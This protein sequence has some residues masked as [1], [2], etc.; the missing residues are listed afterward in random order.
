MAASNE[1]LKVSRCICETGR[2][3]HH[4]PRSVHIP[5]EV[6]PAVYA[7]GHDGTDDDNHNMDAAGVHGAED[8]NEE[9][10]TED[11]EEEEGADDEGG[12][13][14]DDDGNNGATTELW[15]GWT[16]GPEGVELTN[17]NAA[18]GIMDVSD[19]DEWTDDGPGP[20]IG[21]AGS[22]ESDND[23]DD[24]MVPQVARWR[25]NL[26]ALSQV[27][28]LYFVAYK[29]Q[30]HVSRPRSCVTNTL[31]ATPDLVLKPRPSHMS[32]LVGGD[33]DRDN[34]HQVNHLIVGD[35][36]D[37]EIL[38][39]AYDDGDVI[40]Y[41]TR[42][43]DNALVQGEE[44]G[45]DN[46][47]LVQPFFHENVAKSAWGLAVHKK[48]RLIAVGSN[49]HNVTVFIFALTGDPYH[50]IPGADPAELFRNLV[51]DASGNLL[52][53][54]GTSWANLD[55]EQRAQKAAAMENVVRRRDANWRI[56]LETN[57]YGNNIPNVAFTNDA[58]GEAEK[59][60]AVDVSGNLW[61]MD[62][63]RFDK[64][65]HVRIEQIHR[66][67]SNAASLRRLFEDIGNPPRPRGWGVLVLPESSFLPVE[68]FQELLGLPASEIRYA[69]SE[70]IGH[71]IDIS[72]GIRHVKNNSAQHPWLRPN[73]A[74]RSMSD[75]DGDPWPPSTWF[76]FQDRSSSRTTPATRDSRSSPSSCQPSSRRR[77]LGVSSGN[78]CGKA[79]PKTILGDGSSI[80]RTY[81][82]D[83]E[84]RSFEEGGVGIMFEGAIRQSRRRQLVIPNLALMQERLSNLLH[85]PELS[86]VVAASMCGRVA[87]LTLT[88]PKNENFTFRRGF[89]IEA[90]LPTRSDEDRH[91]RPVCPLL[92]VAVSPVFLAD[93][94]A[95]TDKAPAPRR[96]RIMLH[97][98]DLRILSYELSRDS[99]TDFL[100]VV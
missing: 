30:I 60:A 6:S 65:P 14:G 51:K 85:V 7:F 22:N 26:T 87:L 11:E 47:R 52:N 17:P 5:F 94:R 40:A 32:F 9:G 21:V 27:Y 74:P 45:V 81:E 92:G 23:E 4:L 70:R 3:R 77:Q 58:D 93:K 33:I 82:T 31:P 71:W 84:L 89:K 49:M 90:I 28:N 18:W 13:D 67:P 25:L 16:E 19:E 8:E 59:I 24:Q 91:L 1:D 43:I 57:S 29:N 42:H 38:L 62:I 20:G 95:E 54:S 39:L 10:E 79:K 64:C 78:L 83:L 75:Q 50:H 96:Y 2:K 69:A 76:D 12:D 68:D 46:T 63:W 98:Y 34:P 80:L 100:S 48:S 55:E 35:L 15:L 41:Y 36:G 88:R 73:Q 61:L 44:D 53:P 66:S 56:L 99:A 72:R 86:M 97:Y 37:E